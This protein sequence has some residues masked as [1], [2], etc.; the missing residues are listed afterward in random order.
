M[1]RARSDAPSRA[2]RLPGRPRSRSRPSADAVSLVQTVA[3]CSQCGTGHLS[4]HDGRERR[5]PIPG[6]LVVSLECVSIM[7]Q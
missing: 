3:H 4:A 5:L 2:D 1:A 7:R 6:V